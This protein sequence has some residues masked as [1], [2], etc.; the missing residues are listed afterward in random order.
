M[1]NKIAKKQ[2]KYLKRK[3]RSKKHLKVS[4]TR[5]RLVIFRSNKYLYIQ[6]MDDLERKVICSLSSISSSLKDKK[7]GKSIESAKVLGAEMAKKVKEAGFD[8]VAFDRNGFLY[9][10]KIQAIADSMRENGISF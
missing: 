10:G 7:L 1:V 3:L 4:A 9:H 2:K 5:P 8:K 6:L